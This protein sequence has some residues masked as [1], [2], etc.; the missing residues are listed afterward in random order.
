MTARHPRVRLLRLLLASLL[1]AALSPAWSQLLSIRLNG[2]AAGGSDYCQVAGERLPGSA[3][4]SQPDAVRHGGTHC[5][6]CGKL[7]DALPPASGQNHAPAT[8]A[9][10]DRQPDGVDARDRTPPAWVRLPARAPP[11]A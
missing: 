2:P 3:D 9:R 5:A 6:L 1:F 10:F 4:S 7:F 11:S 8:W